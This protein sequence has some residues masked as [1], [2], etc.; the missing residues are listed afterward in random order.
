M[1]SNGGVMPFTAAVSGG[2]T[3][4]TLFSGPAAGAQAS[5]YLAGDDAKSG[6]VTLDMGGTS[7]DIA[8]IEGGAPLEVTEMMVARRPLGVPA[9]DLTT[10]S[11]GGGSIAW[12]DRGGFLCVGPQSA[13]AD[14]G[15]ACYG[16]G[17]EDPTVT[18]ADIALGYLN[19]DYFLG[20]A[21]ILDMDASIRALEARIG[22]PL[23]MTAREAAAGIRR[24]VDQR[25]ADEV[26]VFAARRGVD[27][28][29]FTLL[30][31]GGAGAVH[32]AAVADELDIGRILVPPQPGAFSALG[33]L[34]TDV[35]HDYVRSE[36]RPLDQVPPDHAEAIF[37][38]ME[39][40]AAGE[41]EA[42]GFEA[43]D[44]DYGRELD[45]RYTG[46][47]YELRVALDG[48]GRGGLD[49][50]SMQAARE[51]FDVHHARIHGHAARE[52]PVEIVSYRLRV[53]VAV[54]KYQPV[55]EDVAPSA[56][57]S[58]EAVKGARTVYFD[59]ASGTETTIYER[60]R[61]AVG[62]RII[63]P[64]IIEQFD[65]TT[66]LPAGWTGA[67]DGY[68]NLILTREG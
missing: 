68:R 39:A 59:A 35:V 1:Q 50:D 19:P 29:D 2:K 47:G 46:Q 42:E 36:L 58:G 3:V 49:A 44:A 37:A 53:R 40:R 4:Y 64:A 9:L 24:I 60:T 25:M 66:V 31:F 67:V 51:R 14:P 34:C 63:G 27:A 15:P 10:I 6:I 5:A 28:R 13:G 56:A 30:P 17:G 16:N 12:I 11:A 54:P 32:G 43:A 62:A 52:R 20:G 7:C 65:A 23:G 45:M 21:Q 18:D 41:L 26:K 61:L 22:G 38:A 33:L 57:A 8:F 48:L 55:A